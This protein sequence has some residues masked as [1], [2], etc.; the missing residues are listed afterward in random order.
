MGLSSA[1]EKRK[2]IFVG[3]VC[4]VNRYTAA[5]FLQPANLFR[6]S[7]KD[8][9]DLAFL[10]LTPLITVFLLLEIVQRSLTGREVLKSRFPPNTKEVLCP[11]F[12]DFGVRKLFEK[13]SF[14]CG[15][16]DCRIGFGFGG[17][18]FF[19]LLRSRCVSLVGF[20]TQFRTVI[21]VDRRVDFE[22]L[23]PVHCAI[24]SFF[25]NML[26]KSGPFAVAF[27]GSGLLLA[28]RFRLPLVACGAVQALQDFVRPSDMGFEASVQC[29]LV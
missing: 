19:Y 5:P 8:A 12:G 20:R 2:L 7:P 4:V 18:E 14:Q 22:G 24:R 21:F 13:R 11:A 10:I 1:L 23:A 25:S 17:T 6:C 29:E 15:R 16:G 9:C 3:G 26:G 28:S 27:F